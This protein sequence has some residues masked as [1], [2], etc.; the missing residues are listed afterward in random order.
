MK[1]GKDLRGVFMGVGLTA[2]FVAAAA[3]QLKLQVFEKAHTIDLANKTKRYELS[4]PDPAKRGTIFSA[5][6]QP[7]AVDEATYDLNVDFTKC[8]D[9]EGFWL[10]L[11]QA[12]GIPATEFES[13]RATGAKTKLWPQTITSE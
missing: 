4:R 8:P 12:T 6:G 7:L 9:N 3:S 10:D 11:A 2:F 5:D 1:N 13:A